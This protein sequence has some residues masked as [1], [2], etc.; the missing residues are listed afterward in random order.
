MDEGRDISAGEGEEGPEQWL[1]SIADTQAGHSI[2]PAAAARW[3]CQVDF[4]ESAK[5][6]AT[7][8]F[9]CH[10]ERLA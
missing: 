5:R 1:S 8:K 3:I 9:C 7:A 4:Y 10:D 2:H 6:V